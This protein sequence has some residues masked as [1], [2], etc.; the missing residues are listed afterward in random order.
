[1]PLRY[2]QQEASDKGLEYFFDKKAKKPVLEIIPTAGGKSHIFADIATKLDAPLVIFQPT[3]EILEQNYDKLLHAGAMGMTRYSASCGQRD[4]G[5]ITL[6]TIGSVWKKPEYFKHFKYIIIDECHLF[7]AKP[8]MYRSFFDAV[9][10]KMIG[11]S[12]TPWRQSTDGWGGTTQK[13]LTRTNPRIF[14]KVIHVTQIRDLIEQGYLSKTEYFSV[15]RLDRTKIKLNSTGGDYDE[16]SEREYYDKINYSQHIQQVI[17]RLLE[18]GKT[19]II[20]F[21]KFIRE[22]KELSEFIGSRACYVSGEMDLHERTNNIKEFRDGN[23]NVLFNVGVTKLGFDYPQ[24][25]VMVDTVPTRSLTTWMQKVGRVLRTHPEK[26][27]GWVIDMG[28]NMDVFGK[29]EDIDILQLGVK[30]EWVASSNGRQLTNIYY[31]EIS[32]L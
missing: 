26:E 29:V 2:Y 21:T 17:N 5:N 15:K 27:L 10:G 12:A 9:G 18:R 22:S 30:N 31:N 20:C 32:S 7:S 24:L 23:K 14:S 11:F 28:G 8:S 16:Q 4:I 3:A 25:Q 19:S 13:F 6:A 1:M